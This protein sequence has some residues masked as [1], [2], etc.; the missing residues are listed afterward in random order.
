MSELAVTGSALARR[1]LALLASG[2]VTPER[3][4]SAVRSLL[5]SG[6]LDD[7]SVCAPDGEVS[8]ERVVG[9]LEEAV[10]AAGAAA[11]P[12]RIGAVRARLA[13][14][15]AMIRVVGEPGYPGRLAWAWPELGAPLWLA[16]RAGGGLLPD[17][18]AVAVVGTRH[19]TLEGLRTATELAR[20]LARRGVV[21][22]SG[23][24]RGIDQAAHRGALEVGGPSVGV[25][26]AGFDV[27]YPRGDAALREDVRASGGL[28]TEL[29]P[30]APP[31]PR[32]FLARNRIISGLADAVVVVEG[33]RR[34]GALATARL[35]A[36][37]GRDVWA[38]PGPLSAPTSQ[39]PLALI[40]DGAQVLTRFDDLADCLQGAG[41]SGIPA[42]GR[43]GLEDAG[44]RAGT[45]A[46]PPTAPHQPAVPASMSPAAAAVLTL[47]GAVPA[48]P[49][50]LAAASGLP[51]PAVL[52][53]TSELVARGL[54]AATARG[55]VRAT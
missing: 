40:R 46:D 1:C 26:G 43:S 30:D 42:E 54:A 51:L 45:A 5:E 39:A 29:A 52:A 47:L 34:S 7:G 33:G 44:D 37:Q 13:A 15:G 18:P 9:L 53:A 17:G 16:L 31:Q 36:A 49:G 50:D 25:L 6:P 38:V 32:N 35:A 14:T 3:L 4:A 8:A 48:A 2:W 19:P 23:M 12:E 41:R 21:V 11:P 27:D 10:R 28:V 55:L 22:V 24:A 20:W